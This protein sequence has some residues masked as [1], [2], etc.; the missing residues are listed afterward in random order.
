MDHAGQPSPASDRRG[1]EPRFGMLETIGEF[2]GDQRDARGEA[3]VYR[4]RQEGV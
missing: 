1:A 4:A 3:A 2:A